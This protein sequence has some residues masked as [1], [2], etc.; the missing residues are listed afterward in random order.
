MKVCIPTN[1][2]GGLEDIVC[3][4]FG[5]APTFTV[6]DMDTNSVVVVPNASE[7]MGGMGK[8]PEHIISTGSEVLVCSELGPRAIGMFESYGVEVFVGAR[9]TVREAVELWRQ[10]KL[11]RAS[12]VNACREHRH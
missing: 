2:R 10:G 9:G 4:H 8:P 5:R 3:E 1:G 7:H 11:E 12:D 6:V